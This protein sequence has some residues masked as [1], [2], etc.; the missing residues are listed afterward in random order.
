MIHAYA[1]TLL[2]GVI[3]REISYLYNLE[4]VSLGW[5]NLTGSI[6]VEIFNLSRVTL[7]SLAGNQLSGNLPSTVFYGLPNLEQ[8][9]LNDNYIVGDLPESNYK[10]F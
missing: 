1:Y 5:N 8:L 4:T 7:M 6:P 3:P 2:A 10:F 9:Y